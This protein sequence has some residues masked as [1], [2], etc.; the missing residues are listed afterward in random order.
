M[1]K[2]KKAGK[3]AKQLTVDTSPKMPPDVTAGMKSAAK[4]VEGRKPFS[5]GSAAKP[6]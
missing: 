3:P 4:A 2:T 1:A 6:C 5:T